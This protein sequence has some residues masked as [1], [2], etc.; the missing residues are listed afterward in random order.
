VAKSKGGRDRVFLSSE[1]HTTG[2]IMAG[3]T[4]KKT[5]PSQAK[6][7]AREQVPNQEGAGLQAL[8]PI[9]PR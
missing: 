7:E 1:I 9:F 8:N 3:C 4:V 6:P 5:A 2:S